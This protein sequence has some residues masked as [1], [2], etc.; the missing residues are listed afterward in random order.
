MSNTRGFTAVEVLVAATIVVVFLVGI[1]SMMPTAYRTIDWS[2]EETVAVTLT[3]QRLEW[4]RNQPF[5]AAAMAAGTTTENL[6][7]SDAGYTRTTTIQDNTP[8]N[9]VK[10]VTVTVAT[11]ARRSVQI[12]TLIAE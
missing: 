6:A 8:I 11:P 7:G 5:T 12:V 3:K 10:Q 1:A 4:L 9:A 2:G